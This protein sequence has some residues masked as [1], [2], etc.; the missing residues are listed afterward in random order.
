MLR[1]QENLA[2]ITVTATLSYC[3]NCQCLSSKSAQ[4]Q[5]SQGWLLKLELSS[6][7]EHEILQNDLGNSLRQFI[8]SELQF[9]TSCTLWGLVLLSTQSSCSAQVTLI[10][11]LMNCLYSML[12]RFIRIYMINLQYLLYAIFSVELHLYQ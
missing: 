4:L 2:D 7:S 12:N 8:F 9:A 1:Q 6:D 11:Q 5:L 10:N 3:S